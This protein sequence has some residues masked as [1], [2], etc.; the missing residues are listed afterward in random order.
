M[1]VSAKSACGRRVGAG[2]RRKTSRLLALFL[3]LSACDTKK[4]ARDSAAPAKPPAKTESEPPSPPKPPSKG[5][6]AEEEFLSIKVNS[7]DCFDKG[8][9]VCLERAGACRKERKYYDLICANVKNDCVI[10]VDAFCHKLGKLNGKKQDP[11]ASRLTIKLGWDECLFNAYANC[12]DAYLKC[13]KDTP[14]WEC[15]LD[16]FFCGTE[17]RAE[18]ARLSIR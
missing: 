6:C 14:S 9:A 12:H 13:T 8:S 1:F 16:E 5:E 11:C 17:R 10:A 18:C 3:L 7:Q 2:L 4:A 15:N